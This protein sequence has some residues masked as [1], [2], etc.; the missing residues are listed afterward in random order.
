[1]IKSLKKDGQKVIFV[2]NKPVALLIDIDNFNLSI[3]EPFDFDFG[4]DG[5]DPQILLDALQ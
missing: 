2:N 5:I 3:E 1:L 4:A